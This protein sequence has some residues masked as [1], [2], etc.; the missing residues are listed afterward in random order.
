[1]TASTR[2]L[3]TATQVHTGADAACLTTREV[4]QRPAWIAGNILSVCREYRR[5]PTHHP[6][7]LLG[8]RGRH[9]CTDPSRPWTDAQQMSSGNLSSSKIEVSPF[10]RRHSSRRRWC[11]AAAFRAACR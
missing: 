3:R 10:W 6:G 9:A 11:S 1:M 5:A 8:A 7:G 4:G 2:L